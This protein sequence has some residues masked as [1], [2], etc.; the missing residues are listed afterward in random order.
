MPHC[1]MPFFFIIRPRADQDQ[2]HFKCHM[3]TFKGGCG[4]HDDDPSDTQGH[5]TH[6]AGTLVGA[7]DNNDVLGGFSSE[8]PSTWTDVT[9]FNDYPYISGSPTQIGLIRPD[10]C[11][12]E[13]KGLTSGTYL[14][15]ITTDDAVIVKK[16]VKL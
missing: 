3:Q 6:V 7:V 10:V 14:V 12:P 13:L 2:H 8:G 15:K 16:V 1:Y 11:A 5:G 9:Q 4:I